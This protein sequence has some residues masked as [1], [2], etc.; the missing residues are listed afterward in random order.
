MNNFNIFDY[1]KRFTSKSDDY[2]GAMFINIFNR[3]PICYR[4]FYDK[5]DNLI[6]EQSV[7]SFYTHR[8][9]IKSKVNDRELLKKALEDAKVNEHI[10]VFCYSSNEY[11]ILG[12]KGDFKFLINVTVGE[13]MDLYEPYIELYTDDIEKSFD[14]VKKYFTK[15]EKENCVEFGIAAVDPSNSVYT[16]WYDYSKQVI[17]IDIDKNYNDD[18]KEPYNKI[19]E[20]IE[21]EG[22]ADLMLFYGDPGTGKSS[23]IKHL[24]TKY[25]MK[26]FIFMDG[27]LLAN[28]SQEKLMSY[29]LENNDTI[30]IFEDC[31]K[32]LMNREH[33]YNPVMPVLLNLTDGIISDVLGIKIICTFNT[34]LNQIDPALRRKGRLSLKYEFKKLAKEK[35][36][37]IVDESDKIKDF[38]V[39]ED[40]SLAELYNHDEENDFSKKN[41]RKI[42]F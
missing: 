42:G 27:G 12:D 30:F 7:E 2:L 32:I 39:T 13:D 11:L 20:L 16:S 37:K 18:F 26:D 15:A 8:Q 23:L 5:D 10:R 40:M 3:L 33:H 19:C 22:Q 25:P 21:A 24:I 9:E 4:C 36:Q 35:C 38:T 17:N 6:Y 41:T 31:E 29:F 14:F 34:A 1:F 28:V